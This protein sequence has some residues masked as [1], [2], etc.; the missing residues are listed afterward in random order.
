MSL[1]RE[2][3][4]KKEKIQKRIDDLINLRFGW[5]DEIPPRRIGSQSGRPEE[6]K[7]KKI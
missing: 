1:E 2:E 7:L 4:L 6:T 3:V 5:S